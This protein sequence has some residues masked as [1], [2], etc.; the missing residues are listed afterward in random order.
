MIYHHSSIKKIIFMK[1]LAFWQRTLKVS[2]VLCKVWDY[3][4]GDTCH[5]CLLCICISILFSATSK[6]SFRHWISALA[7][8]KTCIKTNFTEVWVILVQHKTEKCSLYICSSLLALPSNR[9]LHNSPWKY[10]LKWLPMCTLL[11][12][13]PEVQFQPQ[14]LQIMLFIS[15]K[16]SLPYDYII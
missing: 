6:N 12:L 13:P 7:I 9:H 8:W 14:I 11:L 2:L 10:L 4:G 16:S 15:K 5:F 1:S 3:T